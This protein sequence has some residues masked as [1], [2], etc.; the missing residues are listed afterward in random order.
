[1]LPK[2]TIPP[3]PMPDSTKEPM[4]PEDLAM[5]AIDPTLFEKYH[6]MKELYS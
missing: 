3:A 2:L 1:M 6:T 5:V 4:L